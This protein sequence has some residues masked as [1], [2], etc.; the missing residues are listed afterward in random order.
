MNQYPPYVPPPPKT[1]NPVLW[2]LLGVFL[3]PVLCCG[4]C[5][6]VSVLGAATAH[7]ASEKS[8]ESSGAR[9]TGRTAKTTPEESSRPDLELIEAHPVSKSFGW[10]AAGTVRNN[11][12]HEYSYVQVEIN[13]YD[14]AGTLVDSTLAN[15]N[16][17]EPRGKWKFEA[18]VLNDHARTWK[19]KAIT[20]Y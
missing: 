15:V 7:P 9:T 13:L 10:A 14:K 4:G 20:G 6:G 19:V 12:D 11:T 1:T 17:L 8:V 3:V 18:P 16:N 5:F 2:I